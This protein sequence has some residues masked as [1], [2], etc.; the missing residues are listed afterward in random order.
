MADNDT[1]EKKSLKVKP[2][3]MDPY[4]ER[5]QRKSPFIQFQCFIHGKLDAE[6]VKLGSGSGPFCQL[7]LYPS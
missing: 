4:K 6:S 5:Q 2:Y 1:L 7:L 3:K